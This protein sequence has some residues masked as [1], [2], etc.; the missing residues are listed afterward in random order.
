[1]TSSSFFISSTVSIDVTVQDD[2]ERF[3][4][5]TKLFL[6]NPMGPKKYGNPNEPVRKYRKPATK[7]EVE[8]HIEMRLPKGKGK[9]N[10]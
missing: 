5:G 6:K 3:G 10:K 9:K 7:K 4:K 1:M 8:A 2:T